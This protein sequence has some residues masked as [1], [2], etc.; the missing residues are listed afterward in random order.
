MPNLRERF[1][2]SWNAFLDRNQSDEFRFEPGYVSST[3]PD[4][5]TLSR[6]NL[7]TIVSTIIN[8]IAVDC[9]LIDIRH[10]RLNDQ[11][12]YSE[13]LA[14]SLN[15]VLTKEANLDQTGRDL[16]RDIVTSMLD[17]GAVAVVPTVVDINP[18]NTDGYKIEEVRTGRIVQWLPNKVCVELYNS[19]NGQKVQMWFDKRTTA[20]MENPFY[21]IMNEPNSTAQR[22]IRVLNQLDKMND[23]VSSGKMDLI[24][25]LPYVVKSPAVEARAEAR[26]KSIEGQLSDSK[27]GI[28]YID[29]T[30]KV[31]QLNRPVE[32]NLWEQAEK[33]KT[34]LFNQLGIS[35]AILDQTADEQTMQNYYSTIIEP[36]MCEIV[37]NMERKWISKTAQTQGQAIRYFRNPFRLTPISQIAE[38]ADK[39][40]RNEILSSNELRSSIGYAPSKDPKADQLINANIN[41][42]EEEQQDVASNVSEEGSKKKGGT[43]NA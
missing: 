35:Q 6:N 16:T 34:D 23:Q 32:N 24:I 7:R 33:L 13:T 12:Q 1:R 15:T 21:T 18:E 38:M 2:N 27:Y 19:V 4:R 39:F 31:V 17:E 28:A 26:R 30:E 20:I 5:T 36:I 10:V 25:Q 8:R 11:N 14:T 22:L 41:H 9:S 40:T 43:Q 29:G 37:E 42:P 3:R